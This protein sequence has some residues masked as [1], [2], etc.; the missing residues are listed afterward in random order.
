MTPGYTPTARDLGYESLELTYRG[1]MTPERANQIRM[2]YAQQNA[3]MFRGLGDALSGRRLYDWARE[4]IPEFHR[5]GAS[6]GMWQPNAIDA[7]E[8]L[9]KIAQ[10]H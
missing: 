3:H 7:G 9:L 8:L 1:L 4:N 2:T 10:E 5:W 6:F